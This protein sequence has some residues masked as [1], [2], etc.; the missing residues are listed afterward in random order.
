MDP[1]KLINLS[2]LKGVYYK[3]EGYPGKF[4]FERFV[5]SCESYQFSNIN[6]VGLPYL[7]LRESDVIDLVEE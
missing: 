7:W 5:P 1:S 4:G 3:I 2:Y 6:V